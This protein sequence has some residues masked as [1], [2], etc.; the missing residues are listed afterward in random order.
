M[1]YLANLYLAL[2]STTAGKIVLGDFAFRPKLFNSVIFYRACQQTLKSIHDSTLPV[3][4]DFPP[5]TALSLLP[6]IIASYLIET[7]YAY[8][9]AI[10]MFLTLLPINT[11]HSMFGAALMLAA[12]GPIQC[13]FPEQEQQVVADK[14]YLLNMEYM[15]GIENLPDTKHRPIEYVPDIENLLNKESLHAIECQRNTLLI[16][17]LPDIDC[18]LNSDD[19][20]KQCR[21]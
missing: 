9:P 5:I 3:I 6:P 20:G 1:Q 14:P 8:L 19:D 21:R 13:E 17:Y 16:K 10:A 12:A 7:L 11:V 18:L 4:L 2:K 15:S